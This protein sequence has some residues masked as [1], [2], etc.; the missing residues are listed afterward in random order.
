MAKAKSP[1]IKWFDLNPYT[2]NFAVV[3][4]ESDWYEEQ[5]RLG[6]HPTEMHGWMQ[7]HHQAAVVELENGE[8]GARRIYMLL[9]PAV[10]AD[11]GGIEA[12]RVVCHESV[13]VW[14]AAAERV[15]ERNP[16]REIEAY[17]IDFIFANAMNTVA[18][19]VHKAMRKAPDKRLAGKGK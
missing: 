5:D 1:R 11:L 9:N 2:V 4:A 13:H 10:L 6:I 19:L 8:T 3:T 18:P 16:S 17:M 14:Q 7:A 12:A 15:G